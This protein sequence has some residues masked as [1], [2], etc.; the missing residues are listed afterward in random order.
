MQ[1]HRRL[2][3]SEDVQNVGMREYLEG[4]V[5]E[6]RQSLAASGSK[7]LI[8]VDAD[9]VAL[10]TDRAVSLG[11]VVTELVTNAYKYAYAPDSPGE[12]RIAFSATDHERLRLTVEDDGAGMTATD[13][14]KG[15]GLGRKVI[16]AMARSL[17][18]HVEIDPAHVGTRA[19]LEFRVTA[20][21]A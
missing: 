8:H 17:N 5:G 19:V 16:A 9:D 18:S 12:I 7:R 2:Y 11:V 13:A 20:A 15:T 6:L 3:T 10:E 4:L 14:P 1:V 21:V